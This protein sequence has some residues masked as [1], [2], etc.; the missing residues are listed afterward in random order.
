MSAAHIETQDGMW[1]V[2]R[3]RTPHGVIPYPL[4]HRDIESDTR[5]ALAVFERMGVCA[6]KQVLFIGAGAQWGQDWPYQNAAMRIATIASYAENSPFDAYRVE[7][8][9]R[10]FRFHAVLGVSGAILDGLEQAG[11]DLA[12]VFAHVPVVCAMVEAAPRLLAKGV[13]CWRQI[14]LGATYAFESPDEQGARYDESEWLVESRDGAL[15]ISARHPR[16][17]PFVRLSSGVSGALAAGDDR[18]ILL[19][20]AR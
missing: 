3:I 6:G 16:A 13:R 4:S 2:G 12:R 19:P 10:R 20:Q 11:H 1:G 8:F 7:M 18:R 15:L 17:S 5:W 14:D 9:T